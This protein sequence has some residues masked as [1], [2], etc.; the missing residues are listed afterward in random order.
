MFTIVPEGPP[1]GL[2]FVQSYP[3]P[4]GSESGNTAPRADA[5]LEMSPAREPTESNTATVA[6]R[7]SPR[8]SLPLGSLSVFGYL[9][10]ARRPGG[11]L[12]STRP[13]RP[14]R[15]R[16]KSYIT[17]GASARHSEGTPLPV[18]VEGLRKMLQDFNG[19]TGAR[20]SAHAKAIDEA[21][22]KAKGLLGEA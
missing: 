5:V 13:L 17:K 2:M 1:L 19:R 4:N 16:N 22:T 20:M 8:K 21:I 14:R 9:A 18:A 11:R 15:P 10:F 6:A 12:G 7:K 3:D